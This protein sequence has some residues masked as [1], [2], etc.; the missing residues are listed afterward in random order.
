MRKI[1]ITYIMILVC[2]MRIILT[3]TWCENSENRSCNSSISFCKFWYVSNW[4]L[5]CSTSIS[6]G[7]TISSINSIC[8]FW[9]SSDVCDSKTLLKL[10]EFC[11]KILIALR[12]WFLN[13]LTF[14]SNSISSSEVRCCETPSNSCN[15]ASNWD[16]TCCPFNCS[17]LTLFQSLLL[18]YCKKII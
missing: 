16:A 8:F 17:V 6:S 2:N 5:H 1:D 13:G 14:F 15:A 9:S 12:A 7:I 10:S 3:L 18:L 4:A 11:L